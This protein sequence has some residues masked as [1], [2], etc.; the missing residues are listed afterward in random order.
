VKI[1]RIYIEQPLAP[2]QTITLDSEASKYLTRV[3]RRQVGTPLE[4][5]N[6][7]GK[8]Y[9]ATLTTT[10][11]DVWA[12]ITG[13]ELN[14]NESPLQISLVQALAKG[15]KLDLVIQKATELGVDRIIPVSNDRS[16][17]RIE[18]D[19]LE[20]KIAHWK[21]V[22]ISACA[23]CQRSSI[24]TIEAPQ[25]FSSWLK[26][27]NTTNTFLLHPEGSETVGNVELAGNSCAI[28]IGPEG[29][30]SEHELQQAKERGV[31]L[32]K[33]GPRVLRTETAGFTAIAI[34]Q[35]RF[36]DLR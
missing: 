13:C 18:S 20:R 5:F 6:G 3:L 29:G 14:R 7:D 4:L 27:A 31:R 11:K 21:S 32:I 33:C 10:G 28:A 26:K 16:V 34:M 12:T 15:T 25:D 17:L 8:N 19:R 35:A 22:A 24:P 30:F 1:P 2:E 23:Q 36:G 9:P